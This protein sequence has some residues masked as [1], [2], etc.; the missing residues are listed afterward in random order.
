[1]VLLVLFAA[2]SYGAVPSEDFIAMFNETSDS[3]PPDLPAGMGITED[4]SLDYGPATGILA[5]KEL[6]RNA[7][8]IQDFSEEAAVPTNEL[9]LIL[10]DERTK[11]PITD[12]H[13]RL[14]LFNGIEAIKTLRYAG[15]DAAIT[16]PLESSIWEIELGI[17]D[18]ETPGKDY[19][20]KSQVDLTADMDLTVYALRVGSIRGEVVDADSNLMTDAVVKF[21]CNSEYLEIRSATTDEFGSFSKEWIPVGECR[22]SALKGRLAGSKEVSVGHGQI[23]FVTVELT[24]GISEGRADYLWLILL[25]IGAAGVAFGYIIRRRSDTASPKPENKAIEPSGRMKDLMSALDQNERQIISAL[26]QSG[27]T[28]QQNKLARE[29][30]LP[31]SSLSRTLGSLEIRE[32]IKT[33]KLGRIKRVE[34]SDWFL[35]GKRSR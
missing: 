5:Q 7:A 20:Y 9:T 23:G 22:I 26:L 6:P 8:T 17:D 16:L 27:G 19:Y 25:S 18:T 13:I 3:R 21:D 2:A 1:M 29:L 33:E 28:S 11:E 30:S 12:A 31:K 35:N 4:D 14:Y 15:D 34:L 32:L 24:Q 10:L